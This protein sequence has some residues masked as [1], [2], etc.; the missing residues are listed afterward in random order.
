MKDLETMLLWL[1]KA[2]EEYPGR[3]IEN[4]CDNVRARIKYY[5]EHGGTES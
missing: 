2:A 4:I 3:T 5:N 1:E